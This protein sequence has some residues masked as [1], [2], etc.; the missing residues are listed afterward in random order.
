MKIPLEL[1]AVLDIASSMRTAPYYK[2]LDLAARYSERLGIPRHE[3]L[4][5][6]RGD[7]RE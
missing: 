2:T 6:A 4:A 3:L 1:Y 5:M 7:D